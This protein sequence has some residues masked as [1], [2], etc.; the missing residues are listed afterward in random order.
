MLNHISTV[1]TAEIHTNA[2]ILCNIMLLSHIRE[3]KGKK[4]S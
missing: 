2:L 1:K 4:T 3:P